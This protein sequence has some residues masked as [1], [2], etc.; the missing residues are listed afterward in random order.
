MIRLK[1]SMITGLAGPNPAVDAVRSALQQASCSRPCCEAILNQ[2]WRRQAIQ[3]VTQP[4]QQLHHYCST[5]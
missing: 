1:R 3:L 5:G 2:S 4:L